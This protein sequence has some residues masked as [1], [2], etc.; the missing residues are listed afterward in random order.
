MGNSYLD[1]LST[2]VQ[3]CNANQQWDKCI[4]HYDEFIADFD[5]TAIAKKA[6]NKNVK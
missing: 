5:M 6:E 2:E 1:S 4:Q 3:E